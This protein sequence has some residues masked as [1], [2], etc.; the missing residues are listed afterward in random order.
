MRKIEYKTE[1][2]KWVEI[3]Y[4]LNKMGEDGWYL[5]T[6]TPTPNPVDFVSLSTYML[7]FARPK[8]DN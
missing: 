5:C 3:K 6:L 8:S 7:I 2:V 1:I 4:I